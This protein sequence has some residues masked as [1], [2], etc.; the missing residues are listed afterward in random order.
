MAKVY[1]HSNQINIKSK[2][3][4]FDFEL[5]SIVGDM[6]VFDWLFGYRKKNFFWNGAKGSNNVSTTSRTMMSIAI[7]V[8]VNTITMIMSN[9]ILT[10][11]SIRGCS[12][13]TSNRKY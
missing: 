7:E 1:I 8:T 13:M 2:S 3:L 9:W 6:L 4:K 12:T 10:T 11:T 5:I